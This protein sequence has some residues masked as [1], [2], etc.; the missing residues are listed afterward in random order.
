MKSQTI[1]INHQLEEQRNKL[2]DIVGKAS[3]LDDVK[4]AL[5]SMP[6]LAVAPPPAAAPADEKSTRS[7]RKKLVEEAGKIRETLKNPD[8]AGSE[9]L[10]NQVKNLINLVAK[11]LGTDAGVRI[12][13]KRRSTGEWIKTDDALEIINAVEMAVFN[14]EVKGY[15]TKDSEAPLLFTVLESAEDIINSLKDK[16]GKE[17]ENEIKKCEN[18]SN[19]CEEYAILANVYAIRCRYRIGVIITNFEKKIKSTRDAHRYKTFAKVAELYRFW[20]QREAS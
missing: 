12:A 9:D 8:A 15:L 7:K 4:S 3:T 5:A 17:L 18:I 19:T 20:R 11:D 2:S 13:K 10:K 6:P 14:W 1:E 16:T